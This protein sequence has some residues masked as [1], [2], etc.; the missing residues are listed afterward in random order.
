MHILQDTRLLIILSTLTIYFIANQIKRHFVKKTNIAIQF[1]MM[2]ANVFIV[3]T[4]ILVFLGQF[5]SMKDILGT[6]ITNSALLV[7]IIGF[8][9]QAVIK[10]FLAGV[11][12]VYS[13]TFR[14][15]DRVK[16]SGTDIVGV[17]E[18]MNLHHTI[19]RL[20]TNERAIVPNSIMNDTIILNNNIIDSQTS[21][22]LVLQLPMTKDP[23]VTK[24]TIEK[25]INQHKEVIN[26]DTKAIIGN[27]TQSHYEIR[28]LIQTNNIDD[29]FK[30]ISELKEEILLELYNK[31]G[32]SDD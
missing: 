16:L 25:I 9:L 24:T 18:E 7:A 4:G 31:K 23:K 17:I 21:Y 6:L 1:L 32:N 26:K 8:S 30:V 19:I 27:I 14:I 15:D 13:E 29:S 2:T 10:N 28:R 3:I 22:P 20:H 11:L 5:E 12:L